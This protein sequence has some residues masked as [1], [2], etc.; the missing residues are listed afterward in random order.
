MLVKRFTYVLIGFLLGC[1]GL[2]LT[3][4]ASAADYVW[5]EGENFTD[6]TPSSFKP[7][8]AGWGHAEFLSNN[9]W[10]QVSI[11]DNKVEST[12]PNGITISYRFSLAHAATYE[13]WNRIGYEFVRSPF[14]WRVD[15]RPWGTVSPD[16]LTTD[17]MEL[18]DWNEV[19]WLK[20]G[21][22]PLAA[23][24]HILQ[25]HLPVTHDANG[26]AQR[27]LYASD[28]LC[29]YPGRF[30]PNGKYRPGQDWRTQQDI[31]AA[32]Q[33]FSMPKPQTPSERAAIELKGLWEVCRDDEALPTVV[34]APLKDYPP[35]H[36]FWTGI[37]VPSDKNE[38]RPD[39]LL[40]HRLWYRTRVFVPATYAGRSFYLVFPENNLNTTVYVNGVYCGFNPNPFVHFQLDI[41]RGIQPGKLNTID[42]GIRDAWYGFVT[43][44]KDPMV[45][46]KQFNVPIN[47]AYMGFQ[48]LAYPIGHAFE[49]G[50]L[51]TPSLVAAGRVYAEDVFCKPSVAQKRLDVELTLRNDAAKPV[52]GTVVVEAVDASTG[53]VARSFPAR[54]FHIPAQ[55][56]LTLTVGG[57]WPNPH[58]WWP[59]DPHLYLLRTVVKL[60][61]KPV[62]VSDTSF[63][64]REWSIQGT[65]L[66]LNGV[67]FHGWE[68]GVDGNTPEEWLENYR[69]THQTM[70]RLCGVSQGG[71]RPFFGMTPDK[72]LDFMDRNGVVVRRC[73]ILDGEA[74]NYDAGNALVKAELPKNWKRQIVAQVM[75]ERNHPSIMIWSIENEWLYINVINMGLCDFWEPIETEVARA[76]EAADPTRPVMSDGGG[77]TLANTLPVFGNHYVAFDNPGGITAYP[78]MAYQDNPKGGGRGRWVWDEK[79]PRFLGEDFFFTGIHPELSYIG[80][81]QVFSGKEGNIPAC[82]LMETI[83]QQGYRWGNYAAWDFYVGNADTAGLAHNS[84]SPRAVFCRQWDWTFGSG[85]KVSRTMGIFND[86]HDNS[87]ITFTWELQFNNQKVASDSS[88]HSVAPGSREVFSITLPMP[89]V[90]QRTE[91]KLLLALLVDGKPVFQDVKQVSVLPSE[92]SDD[93]QRALRTLSAQNFAVYDPSGTVGTFLQ[94]N[95]IAYTPLAGLAQIPS[96]CHVLLVGK[97]ALTLEESTASH[98]AAF[99]A[100]GGRVI[101]LE[102]GNPLKYQGLPVPMEAQ[103]NDGRVAFIEDTVHPVVQGLEDKDFFTWGDDEVVYRNAYEK[104]STGAA[105]SLIECGAGLTNTALVAIPVGKG[106]MLLSQLLLES[107][108]ADST[109]AQHL[110][111]NLLAYAADYTQIYRQ[112]TLTAQANSAFENAAKA[113]GLLYTKVDDPLQAITPPGDRLAL[114]EASPENLKKLADNLDAV[115]AF[116]KA[117]GWIVFNGLT[118]EGL[119]DYNRIVGFDHMIRPFR[120]E[121]VTFAYP[122]NPLTAGMSASEITMYSDQ[123]IFWWTEGNYVVSDEFSYVVDYDEVAP[124]AKF[125]NDF[126]YNI[127][128]GFVSADGWPLIVDVSVPKSG[129]LDIEMDLPKP[130]TIVRFTWIGNTFYYPTTQVNL[131]FDNDRSRMVTLDTPPDNSPH[132]YD[133]VPPRTGQHITLELAKWKAI[134][135]VNPVIG[136]DNI[137]LYAQRSPEFYQ[138]VKPLLNVGGMMEYPQAQGGILLCNLLFKDTESVPE[139]VVKKRTLLAILL[140]NL[141]APF[142][143][144]KTIIAGQPLVYTPISIAKQA[145][146]FRSDSGWF[147][148]KEHTFANLPVGRHTFAG[149]LYDV[150]DFPTS[151]VPNCIMLGGNGV[152]GN[153]PEEVRGIAV[154]QKADALFFLQ[155]AR[156]DRRRN[157]DELRQGKKFEMADYVVHYADGQTVKIPIYSEIDVENYRQSQPTPVAGAQIAWEGRYPDGSYAVAY[158]MQWNNPRPNV[159]ISSIDLETGPDRVGVPVLLAVTA[160]TVPASSQQSARR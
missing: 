96:D 114:I 30:F 142:A 1:I 125:N 3:N 68:D 112:V 136:V 15:G 7:T 91:G 156:I 54:S 157:S 138:K 103:E 28:A 21:V 4:S 105:R 13:I 126:Y 145:N 74:M 94:Q 76:V 77:A 97:D 38:V 73:G 36:P 40:A 18:Q 59:D 53:V 89:Q 101:V 146:Q 60:D 55:T 22:L 111:W 154:N 50:I 37:P 123:R 79:R 6:F 117:G 10:L 33:V 106:L 17:L 46:R 70:F 62:D 131:I 113:T 137:Y 64:F 61:G 135:G 124:F 130:Q 143:I 148:D 44:P 93:V 122:R 87:P 65:H 92:P 25:I 58:L 31:Q 85:Q 9:R 83:L 84:F 56:N 48:H 72:A 133:I 132:T 12:A 67:V 107:K 115:H 129:P 104:P 69:K 109:V 5:L 100:D 134:P 119:S 140:R 16:R 160:A 11:D 63:G 35:K 95:G 2:L 23:G 24:S 110:L 147:G 8:I 41:T 153:L 159:E 52:E 20:M 66:L 121:R 90:T 151:P 47:F 99:A 102:Q 86:T 144:G 88:V 152:P 34:D 32:H 45:L 149:V 26:K 39:L 49:S 82:G 116:T 57:S 27:I 42:V 155:T 118:P 108:L 29:I 75:A 80:G 19:A 139:N 78:D 81:E 158:S 43:D 150:Y 141:N 98:L 127:V 71:Y 51:A 128:N 14:Q 120:R